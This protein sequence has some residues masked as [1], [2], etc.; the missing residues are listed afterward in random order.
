MSIT[1]NAVAYLRVSSIG[2]VEGDGLTRQREAVREYA[3]ANGITILDEYRDEGVSG[4]TDFADRPGFS[5]LLA[6]IAGNC[7]R[8]VLVERAD[9]LARDLMV[10]ETMLDALRRLGVKVIDASAG[11][12]LNDASDPS[13]VLIRQVMGAVAQWD[14]NC[15][16]AKLRKARIRVRATKGRC[17]GRKPF[18]SRAGEKAAMLRL[19]ELAADEAS[20]R[21]IAETLNAEGHRTRQGKPWSFGTV[22]RIVKRAA[23][24]A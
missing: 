12:D 14:K 7:V 23:K 2:Q 22:G 11:T 16:V 9:R 8:V 1:T 18:G 24:A 6:R 19:L 13:R 5:D 4:A 10:Q 3:K 21:H 20:L 15:L 17:E